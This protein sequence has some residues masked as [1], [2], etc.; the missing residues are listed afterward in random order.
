MDKLYAEAWTSGSEVARL[1]KAVETWKHVA[2]TARLLAGVGTAVA[3]A[4]QAYTATVGM[5]AVCS[6][7]IVIEQWIDHRYDQGTL[8]RLINQWSD[9]RVKAHAGGHGPA[10]G[11]ANAGK[12]TAEALD[13]EMDDARLESV[14]YVQQARK[15]HTRAHPNEEGQ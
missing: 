1:V 15:P 14:A 4:L 11:N 5:A 6:M 8:R 9:L 3:A 13:A 10:D 7:S 12:L 2:R